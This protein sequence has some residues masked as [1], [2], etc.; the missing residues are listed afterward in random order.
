VSGVSPP[1]VADEEEVAAL[2][3]ELVERT[4]EEEE[5]DAVE[6]G[7]SVEE[8]AG[9]DVGGEVVASILESEGVVLYAFKGTL[10][11]HTS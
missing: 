5:E 2:E 10:D 11:I 9:V 1:P 8:P 7:E 6:D 4:E 3:V